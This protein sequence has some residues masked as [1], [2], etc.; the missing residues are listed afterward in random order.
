MYAGTPIRGGQPH[1]VPLSGV[2]RLGSRCPRC[3]SG[4]CRARGARHWNILGEKNIGKKFLICERCGKQ[5]H[6]QHERAQWAAGNAN[7]EYEGYRINQLMV[8]WRKWDDI[9]ADY[10]KYT[11]DRFYNEVPRH[12]VRL[13]YPSSHARGAQSELQQQRPAWRELRLEAFRKQLISDNAPCSPGWTGGRTAQ[14][15]RF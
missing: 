13:R 8:P 12:L 6:P 10:G 9:L 2:T 1:R 5:I 11:R 15:T 4:W 14:A 7:A 3:A